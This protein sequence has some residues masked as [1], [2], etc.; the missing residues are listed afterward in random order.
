M[1]F[2]SLKVLLEIIKLKK[3]SKFFAIVAQ[4]CP[5]QQVLQILQVGLNL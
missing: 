4:R 3:K 2:L 1:V 5:D